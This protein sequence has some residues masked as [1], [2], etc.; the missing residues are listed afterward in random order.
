MPLASSVTPNAA[1]TFLARQRERV[2]VSVVSSHFLPEYG[3]CS[4]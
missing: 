2:V 4:R 1:I 3:D